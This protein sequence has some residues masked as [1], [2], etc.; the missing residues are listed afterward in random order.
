VRLTSIDDKQKIAIIKEV[1]NIMT[2]MN[3]VQVRF[4]YCSLAFCFFC[5]FQAKKFVES[6][7]QTLKEDVGKEE[8]DQLKKKL[9]TIGAKTEVV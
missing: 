9:E 4:A 3:L 5:L 6:L 7:P 8:A 2:G 1:K